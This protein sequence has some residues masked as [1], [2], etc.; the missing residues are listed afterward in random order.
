MQPNICSLQPNVETRRKQLEAWA[1]L[2][3][4]YAEEKKISQLVVLDA[5]Q[6][7]L[8]HNVKLNSRVIWMDKQRSRCRIYWKSPAEWAELIYDWVTGL[9]I[10]NRASRI[11][12]RGTVCTLYEITHGPDCAGER[13]L[14]FVSANF[15]ANGYL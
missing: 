6:C 10:C 8:F 14:T 7:E 4:K 9:M 1:S 15:H 3:L 13:R 11:G 5:Q 12:F 2:V